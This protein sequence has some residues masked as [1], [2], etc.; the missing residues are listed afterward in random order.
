MVRDINYGNFK[1]EVAD[2]QGH[3]RADIYSSVWRDLYEL[4]VGP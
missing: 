3:G 4:Q 1:D 2:K